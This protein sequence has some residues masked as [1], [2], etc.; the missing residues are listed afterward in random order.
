MIRCNSFSVLAP[1]RSGG[2]RFD[3]RVA[4]PFRRR[5]GFRVV[6]RVT[7]HILLPIVGDVEDQFP[8]HVA[9]LNHPMRPG[10]RPPVE[11]FRIATTATIH[12]A[13]LARSNRELDERGKEN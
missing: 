12:R 6:M 8:P 13:N 11:A 2:F 7:L 5:G 9:S 1:L 4:L 10:W 3:M